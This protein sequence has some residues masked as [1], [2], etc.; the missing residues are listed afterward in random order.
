MVEINAG[1]RIDE[2]G[3]GGLKLI[4][5]P[6]DFCYGIDAVL[7][8]D[9]AA[10]RHKGRAD[11]IVDLGTGTGV[12]PL[13]LS[14]RLPQS[15][16]YGI[17]LQEDC[18]ERAVRSAALNGLEERISYINDDV[19]G[20]GE[21]WGAKLKG[22]M[23]IV[24]TNPPYFVSGGGLIN[25]HA[26]KTVARHETTAGLYEFMACASFL[27]KPRG[28]LFMVHRPARLADICCFGR[29]HRL[30]PKELL[31]ISPRRDTAPN[32]LL[33]HMI[34]DGGRELKLLEP[35]CVY[36]EEGGF[37]PQVLAAYR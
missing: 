5:K 7:L 37:T 15:R 18:C 11:L 35:I 8:A 34:K 27:L 13:I 12:I 4:Q 3:F 10:T 20:A 32:L 26:P 28:E 1:E 14:A 33:I 9:F 23:D 22:Q 6:E 24:V 29:E 21:S 25:D 30:E 16:I 2:I 31:F 19:V 17:E 36:D